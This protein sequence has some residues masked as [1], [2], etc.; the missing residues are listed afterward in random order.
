MTVNVRDRQG[1]TGITG[2]AFHEPGRR[3]WSRVMLNQ[4]QIGF[5]KP[6][7]L[8]LQITCAA[9]ILGAVSAAI[10]LVT[11][12]TNR[13][14]TS[15][16]DLFPVLGIGMGLS[17][18]AAGMVIPLINQRSAARQLAA[19][20]PNTHA[21]GMETLDKQALT[22][23]FNPVQQSTIIQ[24]ALFEGP[25]FANLIFWYIDGSVFNLAV[26]GA[27]LALM[28]LLFPF[29]NRLLQSVERIIRD[30]GQTRP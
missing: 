20:L 19:S 12:N 2:I 16:L 22:R 4:Q 23:F 15:D 13:Q 7:M 25:I 27:G 21:A 11:V 26:A 3:E 5:L 6:L 9:L 18:F 1:W 24:F 17:C 28:I 29:S 8:T 14:F 30:A 10:V